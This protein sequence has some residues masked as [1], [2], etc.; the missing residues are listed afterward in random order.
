[1]SIDKEE[2]PYL[3]TWADSIEEADAIHESV[4][5]HTLWVHWNGVS[6]TPPKFVRYKGET[7]TYNQFKKEVWEL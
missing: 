6:M 4:F 1:M 2:Y 3:A 5:P 7:Y